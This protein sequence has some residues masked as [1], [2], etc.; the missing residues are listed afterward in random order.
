MNITVIITIY[1]VISVIIVTATTSHT[2]RSSI[3]LDMIIITPLG[4][5]KMFVGVRGTFQ[6]PAQEHFLANCL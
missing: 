1:I 3:S 5:V 4:M 2:C 6:Q